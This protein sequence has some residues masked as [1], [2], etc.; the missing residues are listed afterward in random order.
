MMGALKGYKPMSDNSVT[1]NALHIRAAGYSYILTLYTMWENAGRRDEMTPVAYSAV[2]GIP[3]PR[4]PF[5]DK[6]RSHSISLTLTNT[7]QLVRGNCSRRSSCC[8]D[9]TP[10]DVRS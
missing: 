5:V 8:E 3:F 10:F 6:S 4:P 9:A 1:D 7:N 2:G